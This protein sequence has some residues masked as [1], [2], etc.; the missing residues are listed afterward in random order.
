VSTVSSPDEVAAWEVDSAHRDQLGALA[1]SLEG[2]VAERDLRDFYRLF[3]ST[4]L[5]IAAAA[6][7]GRT[8]SLFRLCFEVLHRLGSI[9]PATA[10]A[11]ENHYYVTSAIATAPWVDGGSTEARRRLL[12]AVAEKRLL[13]ANTNSKVHTGKLGAIGTCARRRGDGFRVDGTAAYMSLASEAEILVFITQ[14][15]DEGPAIFAIEPLQGSPSIEIGPYLFPTA[16]LDS[17]THRVTFHEL[18]LPAEALLVGPGDAYAAAFISF[19][20]AWHQLLIP[21]LYLGAAAGAIE[22]VRGFART[23]RDKNDRPLAEVDGVVVDVG[24]MAIEYRSACHTVLR[25]GDRLAEVRCFSADLGALES[26]VDDAGVA[27]YVGTRCAEGVVA[28]AR[29]LI[30]PRSFTGGQVLERLSQEV[31]FGPLGPE[32]SSVIERR[33]GR[34][35]LGD[36]HFLEPWW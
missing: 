1:E 8:R 25:A 19:E 16:M 3:R 27:K 28:T 20:M 12:G 9:S 21:A 5:A 26:A 32:V 29:R 10:L 34:R 23:T 24:R 35:A 14:L 6:L 22:A 33:H 36:Q 30:G 11:I 4:D 18:D 15:A 7:E 17:D 31:M 13:V 2:A